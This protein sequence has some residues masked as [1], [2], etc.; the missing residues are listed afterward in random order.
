[1]SLSPRPLEQVAYCTK[2]P[3]DHDDG[4]GDGGAGGDDDYSAPAVGQAT[5]DTFQC[6]I[7]LIPPPD[8]TRWV[9]ASAPRGEEG[10]EAAK[11]LI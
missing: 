4:G 3:D 5:A 6:V 11:W 1:M 8:P 9:P 10:T 7:S 2:A